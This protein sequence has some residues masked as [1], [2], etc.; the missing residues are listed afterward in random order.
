VAA[1]Y[2]A[3][4]KLE[5]IIWTPRGLRPR[6]ERQARFLREIEE[7][8]AVHAGAE[9]VADNLENLKLLLL[10][11]WEKEAALAAAPP[12]APKEAGAPPRV[13][14]ICDPQDEAAIEA[15]ED[16]FYEHGIEVSLPGFE[17]SEAEVHDIHINNLRDCD[18]ALIYYGAAG[19]HWVD[20]N[21]RDLQ[22][23]AGYR[24]ARPIPV[25]AVYLAPPFNRR[26]ERFRSVS[27]EVLRQAADGLDRAVLGAFVDAIRG[28][29]EGGAA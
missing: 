23:A 2:S 17:A 28:S 19:M 1:K 25:G 27:V 6:D 9:L 20:F 12:T 11:R 3:R 5:R 10:R 16:F 13:Y 29:R 8:P 22:K 14:I 18:A 15:L 4:A 7:D 26:K 24:D 21:I